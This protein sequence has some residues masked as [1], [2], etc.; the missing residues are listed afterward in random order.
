MRTVACWLLLAVGCS[1]AL[2]APDPGIVFAPIDPADPLV[3]DWASATTSGVPIPGS[4]SRRMS[5]GLDGT[6][7]SEQPRVTMLAIIHDVEEGRWERID[8]GTIRRCIEPCIE[9]FES[10]VRIEGDRML[11]D[12][13]LAV[14]GA[15]S[16]GGAGACMAHGVWHAT[17]WE[18]NLRVDGT[19]EK[20]A[21]VCS[22]AGGFLVTERCHGTWTE[23]GASIEATFPEPVG[24]C[25]P[26]RC[27]RIGDLANCF[28]YQRPPP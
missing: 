21:I 17:S 14:N 5:F 19:A 11:I 26:L 22:W 12:G 16:F 1:D 18:A 13:Q 3:G 2:D 8:E 6:Y 10:E 9:A 7:R 4:G 15:W 24:R 25:Q 27:R 28:Q 23:T 20:V